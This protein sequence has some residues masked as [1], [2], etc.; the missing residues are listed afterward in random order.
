MTVE[1]TSATAAIQVDGTS[2]ALH[3]DNVSYRFH[4]D[5]ATGD[6]IS[7]HF[8]GP[9][10]ENGIAAEIGPIQGWGNAI[11]RVRREFPDLG[12]GD[13]R[14]PALQIRQAQG[15]TVSDFRYQ[16]HEVVEGKPGLPGLPS[17]FG[18]SEDVSTLIVHMY[19]N[20]SSIAADLSYSIFPKY[21]AIVRSVNVTNKGNGT[22]TLER[23]ASLSVDLPNEEYDMIEMKG[24]WSRE[25]MRVRR[26]VDFGTQGC[27]FLLTGH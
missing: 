6:L 7:D 19:D 12:R 15:H 26:K 3:G 4:V 25:G 16:S 5:N 17:T 27:V 14:T 13:F 2:F 24:D 11:N 8:G 22:V 20:Y 10:P 23:L 18:E 1:L 9:A 21:D